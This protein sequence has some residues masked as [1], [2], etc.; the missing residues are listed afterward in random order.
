MHLLAEKFQSFTQLAR[1]YLITS[2]C[3]TR[4]HPEEMEDNS[5]QECNKK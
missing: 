2:A 1:R 5:V 4:H 3:K